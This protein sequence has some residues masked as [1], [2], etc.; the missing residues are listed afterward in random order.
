MEIENKTP[1]E[2]AVAPSQD[3]EGYDYAVIVVKGTFEIKKGA[4]E[5]PVSDAQ[6]PIFWSDEFYGDPEKSSVKY[7]SD[8]FPSKKGTDVV[9]LGHAYPKGSAKT[10]DV[11]LHAG[12]L[13][14]S[15]R[16]F[17]DRSWRKSMGSWKWSEP[18]PFERMPL[19]YERAFGGADFSD[20][21]PAK[22]GYER[23][24]PVGAGFHVSGKKE[25]L[26]GLPLPNLEDPKNPIKSWKD[27][28]FPAGFGFIARNWVP[29]VDYAGTYDASWQ[30][31]RCPLLPEDFDERYY[32]GASSGLTS[33]QYF[34]GGE[35]I[36]L[37]NASEEGEL[38]FSLPK[39]SVDATLWVKG[40]ETFHKLNL[41]TVII[42][43]DEKRTILVW[44]ATVPC[45]RKFLYINRV[46]LK[47]GS[48]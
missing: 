5:L 45:S 43:P 17:G 30:N 24:N 33:G 40:K 44:R 46:K 42:E 32:N 9:L 31:K 19:T 41:D 14:K 13:G 16:V 36:A 29:R 6:T 35:P 10:V 3:K 1:F 27:K 18:A 20:P 39:R 38:S 25:T 15:L 7:E 11:A 47:E 4:R 8:V 23:R 2:F 22:Q 48:L 34:K 28:P 12:G 21:D 37:M 26:D